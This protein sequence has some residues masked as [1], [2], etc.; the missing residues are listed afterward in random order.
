L[1]ILIIKF[2]SI[3]DVLLTTPL[4]RNLKLHYKD[5]V[6]KMAINAEAKGVL[7]ANRDIDELFLY[8]REQIKK[9][10]KVE[11]IK[12]EIEFAF[13]LRREKFDM[14]INTTEGDRGA[15]LALFSGA[16]IRVGI[17]PQN[18]LLK[19]VYTHEFPKQGGLHAIE[20]GLE[21]LLALGLEVLEK[22]VY[23]SVG[24]EAREKVDKLGLPEE[25]VHIHPLSRWQFKCLDDSKM[26]MIID[27]IEDSGVKC[28]ITASDEKSELDRVQ[29]IL[30]LCKS[31]PIDFAG[32]LSLQEVSEL[33]RRAKFFVGV[34]TAIMHISAANDTPVL[35]FFG[36]SGA[37]HWGPW[38]NEAGECGYKNRNGIQKM[39]KHRV[40]QVDWECAP[41]GKDGCDGSKISKCLIEGVDM[42]VVRE[43]IREM[44]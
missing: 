42:G 11:R 6:I 37:F 1:K 16:K 27:L 22:R 33:N 44:V 18:A 12:K 13:R 23:M 38:D 43:M 31:A 4:L 28:V 40:Y 14:V 25:F 9:G 32:K 10:S 36:P 8:D 29:N 30:K 39:G 26:A 35:A 20:W 24:D 15:F 3:G 2:R 34:D 7:E 5:A 19:N 21:P 17:P 41:C